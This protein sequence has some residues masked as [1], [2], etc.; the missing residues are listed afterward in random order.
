MSGT[1]PVTSM[2][3]ATVTFHQIFYTLQ[4][5]QVVLLQKPFYYIFLRPF[6]ELCFELYFRM[7]D[8][9]ISNTKLEIHALPAC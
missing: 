7:W 9:K 8:L 5:S 1:K 2:T 3:S 4:V 6:L